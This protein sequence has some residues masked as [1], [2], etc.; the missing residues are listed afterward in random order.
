MLRIYFGHKPLVIVLKIW[1]EFINTYQEHL[2]L[3]ILDINPLFQALV[4]WELNI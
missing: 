2:I 3:I 1:E 4:K